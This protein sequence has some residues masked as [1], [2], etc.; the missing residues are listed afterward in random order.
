[1]MRTPT[2]AAR[3]IILRNLQRAGYLDDLTL[4]EIAGRFGVN[5]STIL[6]NLRALPEVEAELD[7]LQALWTAPGL[8]SGAGG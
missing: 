6:R 3:L 4:E 8:G 7:R 2:A 1:M 5:R